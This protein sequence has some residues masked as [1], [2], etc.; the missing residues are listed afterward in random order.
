[1]LASERHDWRWAALTGLCWLGLVGQSAALAEA[2]NDPQ[3]SPVT[4]VE[5]TRE[6]LS[7]EIQLSGTS[8]PQRSVALSPRVAGLVMRVYIDAGAWVKAGDPILELDSQLADIEVE[9]GQAR[10]A[11]AEA[12]RRDALRKRDELLRLKKDRHASATSI[13]SAIAALEAAIADLNRDRAELKRALELRERHRVFAPFAGMVVDKFVEE[14]Q[15]VARDDTLAELIAMDT[16]RLR[17][18]LPQRYFPLVAAD[19]RVRVSFDALPGREFSGRVFARVARGNEASRSF[20]LL[21]DIANPAHVLA[22]G[23]SARVQVEITD[24]LVDALMV[25]RDSIVVRN[26]GQRVVW[27]VRAEQHGLKAFPITIQTG[28]AHGDL[29]EVIDGGL[30]VGD[31]LVMLGNESL[32]PG[33]RV[34]DRAA[35]PEL[36]VD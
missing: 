10:V 6:T 26:N 14:G 27:R 3:A 19:S 21:I 22:P 1:M 34:R 17:A 32:R 9:I 4:L 12:R 8:I 33:Q 35:G 24:G 15:W 30:E 31:R 5:V 18:P 13:E 16:L 23:M 20:P 7:R 29:L 11:G 25:P 28:R 36:A 2:G